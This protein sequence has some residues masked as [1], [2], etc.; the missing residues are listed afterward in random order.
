MQ[1]RQRNESSEFNQITTKNR[2]RLHL[3]K[4]RRLSANDS[5]LIRCR[6]H[7]V[8]RKRQ[9]QQPVT[10]IRQ[11][12]TPVRDLG[13]INEKRNTVL[14]ALFPPATGAGSSRRAETKRRQRQQK[15]P[16]IDERLAPH[17]GTQLVL[18]AIP[19]AEAARRG[20]TRP[21]LAPLC[22]V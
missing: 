8:S 9:R 12:H 3:P 11:T 13:I 19:V 20:G 22:S 1:K 15:P 6:R 18:C 21:L 17:D 10:A 2:A 16:N 14:T 5:G 4:P 7:S